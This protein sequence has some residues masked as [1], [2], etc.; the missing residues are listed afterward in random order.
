MYDI[1]FSLDGSEARV[2]TVE[3]ISGA[4]AFCRQ[5]FNDTIRNVSG[6]LSK[7]HDGKFRW[8]FIQADGRPIGYVIKAA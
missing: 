8:E 1:Y 6:D 4:R 2:D 3:N 5:R 7:R